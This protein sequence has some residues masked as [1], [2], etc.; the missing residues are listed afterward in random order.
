MSK[1]FEKLNKKD[2]NLKYKLRKKSLRQLI[3]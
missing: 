2:K 3:Y 1:S